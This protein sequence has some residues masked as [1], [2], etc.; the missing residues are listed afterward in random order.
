MNEINIIFH[1]KAKQEYLWFVKNN[2][3]LAER[4]VKLV[5]DIKQNPFRGLGKPELLKFN[6]SGI[7]SRRIDQKHRLIYRFIDSDTIE[8]VRCYSHYDNK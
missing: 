3:K 1:E 5:E 7:W 4:I 8:I 2:K 6:F